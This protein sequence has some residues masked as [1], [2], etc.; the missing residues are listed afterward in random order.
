MCIAR[1]AKCENYSKLN[2]SLGPHTTPTWPCVCIMV[3]HRPRGVNNIAI[4]RSETHQ[5]AYFVCYSAVVLACFWTQSLHRCPISLDFDLRLSWAF[6]CERYARGCITY[7]S[8]TAC[9]AV[10]HEWLQIC[11][12]RICSN[13]NTLNFGHTDFAS[14]CNIVKNQQLFVTNCGV[15]CVT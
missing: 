4:G 6:G 7:L 2:T 1:T 9:T 13:N 12:C 3:A 11:G 8:C 15:C 14:L 5:T 10:G